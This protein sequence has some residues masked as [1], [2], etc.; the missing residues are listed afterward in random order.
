[1]DSKRQITLKLKCKCLTRFV[2]VQG[3][4]C[5]NWEREM[6]TKGLD[7][8][9]ALQNIVFRNTDVSAPPG[10]IMKVFVESGWLSL[11]FIG[12]KPA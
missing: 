1:M 4:F 3:H 11:P 5:L 12:E 10:G 8:V 6:W 9:N 2:S 7:V